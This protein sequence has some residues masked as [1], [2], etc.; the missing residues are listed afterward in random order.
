MNPTA[1]LERPWN[2]ILPALF[3]CAT[4]AVLALFGRPVEFVAVLTA[5]AVYVWFGLASIRQPLLFVTV[6]LVSLEVFPPFYFS[7]L[8]ETPVYVSFLLVPILIAV[9]LVRFPDM[10]VAWDPI[11]KGLAAFLVGT[12]LS[13]PFAF[14]LS[15]TSVGMTSLSR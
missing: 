5:A 12:A 15:G 1:A 14:W 6:L 4:G 7:A 9:V 2:W 13:I 3:A 8:G 10:R 11:G